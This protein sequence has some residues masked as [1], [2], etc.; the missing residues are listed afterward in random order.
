MGPGTSASGRNPFPLIPAWMKDKNRLQL[1]R[2]GSQ[3]SVWLSK[4]I[5]WVQQVQAVPLR[6]AVALS[7]TLHSGVMWECLDRL[8]GAPGPAHCVLDPAF[9]WKCAHPGLLSLGFYDTK[10][11]SMGKSHGHVGNRMDA[12]CCIAGWG[13]VR[14]KVA[15]EPFPPCP[16][17]PPHEF[18]ACPGAVAYSG[19]EYSRIF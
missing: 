3:G 16:P 11:D 15:P 17:H 1:Q 14:E 2:M 8:Q 13:V 7:T 5:D 6:T 4:C 10:G 9:H 19:P 12:D 18:E